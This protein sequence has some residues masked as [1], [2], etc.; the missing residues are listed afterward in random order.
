MGHAARFE[1]QHAPRCLRAAS[2]GNHANAKTA[3]PAFQGGHH[4][5]VEIQHR[6]PH[7]RPIAKDPDLAI[8]RAPGECLRHGFKDPGLIPAQRIR[9]GVKAV[10]ILAGHNHLSCQHDGSPLRFN[11]CHRQHR[12]RCE[13]LNLWQQRL[14][15]QTH[16]W[17]T[18]RSLTASP[19]L[20]NSRKRDAL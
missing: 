10:Q 17:A 1:R 6:V 4:P 2:T 8:G 13:H 18:E 12:M 5:L 3:L 14:K 16:V 19:T 9:E 20:I 7:Q 15:D 11:R